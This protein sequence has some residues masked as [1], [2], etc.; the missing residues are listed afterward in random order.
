MAK[1]KRVKT[2]AG[3]SAA[4][5]RL[6]ELIE[7]ATVDCYNESEQISGFFT[8]LEEHIKVPFTATVLGMQVV[9]EEIDLTDDEKIVAVC[10]RGRNR[11]PISILDLPLPSPKPAGAEWIEAYRR[12]ASGR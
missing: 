2:E 4:A 11:Q 6:D 10:R 3:R 9:V 1:I 5:G 7:E 8:M 12:W